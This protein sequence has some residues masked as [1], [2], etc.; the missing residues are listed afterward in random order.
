FLSGTDGM[1]LRFVSPFP[2]GE[3]GDI[4]AAGPHTGRILVYDKSTG[5]LVLYDPQLAV[6]VDLPYKTDLSSNTFSIRTNRAITNFYVSDPKDTGH[7]NKQTVTTVSSAGAF[8]PT[9][10]VLTNQGVTRDC[11]MAPSLDETIL[12]V[13]NS[14]SAN[15]AAVNRWDLVNNVALTDLVAGI[16][17]YSTYEMLVLADGTL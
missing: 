1:V 11:G 12:Y 8:G 3:S 14:A 13:V 2:A 15:A 7:S 17:N 4:I 6:L 9:T 5:D 10:W 16:A